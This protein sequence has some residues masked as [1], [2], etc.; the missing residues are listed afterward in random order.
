[1]A[2]IICNMLQKHQQIVN[3][4]HQASIVLKPPLAVKIRSTIV[5]QEDTAQ[6]ELAHPKALFVQQDITVLKLVQ[7]ISLALLATIV[8]QQEF[9]HL[10][11]CA[12][13]DIGVMEVLLF[14]LQP[15]ILQDNLALLVLIAQLELLSL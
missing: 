9:L 2:I 10:L 5:P 8:V 7:F 12:L 6:V 14:L 1:M 3:L 13:Q 11:P 15:I 4:A